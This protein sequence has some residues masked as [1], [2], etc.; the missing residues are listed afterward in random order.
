MSKRQLTVLVFA[1]ICLVSW[2]SYIER[3]TQRDLRAALRN[4]LPLL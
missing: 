1:T 3:P 2:V 4:T